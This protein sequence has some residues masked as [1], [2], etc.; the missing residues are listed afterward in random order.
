M[1]RLSSPPLLRA[2]GYSSIAKAILQLGTGSTPYLATPA[3]PALLA[4][5]RAAITMSDPSRLSTANGEGS[6]GKGAAKLSDGIASVGGKG[7]RV[8]PAMSARKSSQKKQRK[9]REKMERALAAADASTTSAS[10]PSGNAHL[11]A[12]GGGAGGQDRMAAIDAACAALSCLTQVVLCCKAHLPLAGRMS[13][14]DIV[15]QGLALLA[16]AGLSRRGG[17]TERSDSTP[18]E[19]PR[20]AQKFIELAHACVM[21]PLVSAAC[22]KCGR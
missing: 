16:R 12:A 14:E 10:A 1:A 15:H 11:N 17:G 7:T 8:Q 5:V 6:K 2:A 19:D 22:V 20:M 9:S 13:I 4:E 3:L 18:M 21:T